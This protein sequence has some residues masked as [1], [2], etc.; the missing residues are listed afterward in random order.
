MNQKSI[1]IIGAGMGGLAAG[2]YGQLNGF[3]TQ[4]FEMH[5]LPGGQCAAWKRKGYTF[6]GCIH[7]LM[8]CRPDSRLF[9]LWEELG[10]MPRELC[11]TEDC[12]SV[13]AP[14]GREFRDYYDPARLRDHLLTLA[15][16]DRP[17]IEHYL[18]GIELASRRDIGEAMIFDG[19]PGLLRAA[20]LLWRM[21][22]YLKPTLKQYAER[23]TDPLLRAGFPLVEYSMPD[24]PLFLH[25]MK[26]ANGT[27]GGIK[28]P[29]GGALA[30]ARS[31]EQRY[32]SLGGQVHYKQKV[33][34][35]LTEGHR[36]V[37]IVLEDGTEVRADYV[38]SNADGRKTI[39]E[40][41]GGRF[42][43]E[44]IRAWCAEPD[45][46]TNW[47]VHVFLGVNRDLSKEPS[48]LVML[49][50]KPME[51]AG[52]AC[53]HIELQTYGFDPSM[54]P[55]GKGVIKAELFSTYS[56]WKALAADRAR[57]E[58]EKERI[59]DTVIGLLEPRFPG[60]RGQVEAVDVPTLLTWERYMGGTHGFANMPKKP[61]NVF[62]S[63]SAGG[64]ETT[65]PGLERF[66]FAGAW[67]TSAGALFMNA[68]SGRVVL[69]A[70]CKEEGKRFTAP[71]R[72]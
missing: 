16:A 35:I 9:K 63:L 28:W 46:L 36:T 68:L 70:I 72:L 20:P 39:M 65:L 38:I 21:R 44:T 30:F 23:F 45:D 32:L 1:I 31:I 64:M 14:D 54:A 61:F 8:G 40:M 12:V 48:A 47:A 18:R 53:H 62:K 17:V 33:T 4:I 19:M 24:A 6:D 50:E 26:H 55:P 58:E 2:I 59:A 42:T 60:L 69:Q 27:T 5:A 41:L 29:A 13:W 67:A 43:N 22:S 34:R 25:V 56:Y 57:Y 15:P 11:T 49:L 52:Q 37:G 71:H 51:I 7:H 10:A 3:S 66:H